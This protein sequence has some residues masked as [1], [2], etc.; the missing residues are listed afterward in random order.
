M[1]C[2]CPSPLLARLL[3]PAA[4]LALT[5]ASAN[6]QPAAP[7]V[8]QPAATA[9]SCAPSQGS[10][11]L[12]GSSLAQQLALGAGAATVTVVDLK[13]DREL[14]APAALRERVRAAVAAALGPHGY[15]AKAGDQ[16]KLRVEL[17]IEKSGGV[18]RVSAEVRRATGLWQRIRHA[19]PSA[20]RHGFVEAPLDAELRAL[21]PPPPLVVGEVLKLKAPERGIVALACGPLGGDGGQE[22][23]LVSRGSVRVGRVVGRAFAE[24]KRASW[25]SLSAIAP[26]P[27]REPIASAEITAQGVLRIGLTDRK[28]GLELSRD[29]AVLAR[30]PALLPAPGG[31]CVERSPLGLLARWGSCT[32]PSSS[33]TQPSTLD[34]IAG[35]SG[36]QL[37]RDQASGRL[38]GARPE[39]EL[40]KNR[41]GAQLALGDAD[42]DGTP[43]L[44]FSADT[45]DARSDRL[46]L[47]TLEG[48]KLVP[49]FELPAPGITA[50][51]ICTGREGPGMAP[52][53]VATGDELWLIR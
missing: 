30:F 49:R 22:L 47:V 50:I 21:I 17:S 34:A 5:A 28:D 10:L 20:E 1:L 26:A 18:L 35:Q 6:A 13:S 52:L 11:S 25:S 23:A 45:L 15:D 3:A 43:E 27:L 46:T 32:A 48:N 24:R 38:S 16:R 4:W 9:P 51:A 42:S 8:A 33:P 19:K 37:G 2:L 12:I 36:T 44:A 31:G 39:L 7:S 41:A 53:V 29:L 14:P 40:A